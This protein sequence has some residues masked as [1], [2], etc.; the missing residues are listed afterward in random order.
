[1][2]RNISNFEITCH[3]HAFG[4]V[5]VSFALI[6]MNRCVS[7][8]FKFYPDTLWWSQGDQDQ[9]LCAYQLQLLTPRFFKLRGSEEVRVI[10]PL[11][12][13]N[14]V[15]TNE[16]FQCWSMQKRKTKFNHKKGWAEASRQTKI[17][18]SKQNKFMK[19]GAKRPHRPNEVGQAFFGHPAHTERP[20]ELRR[21][22][23][24]VTTITKQNKAGPC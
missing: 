6:S 22:V 5:E 10:S 17:K 23:A 1:M 7:R 20:E 21:T 8:F 3:D 15:T 16:S 24:A 11:R 9:P 4:G 13:L 18:S 12:V 2:S 19:K 14:R